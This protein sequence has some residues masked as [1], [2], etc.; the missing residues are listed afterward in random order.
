M[1]L[2]VAKANLM[3]AMKTLRLRWDRA[4]EHWDDQASRQF[5]QEFIA[6]L[7]AK[8]LAAAK[9]L[10]QVAELTAQVRRDCGDDAPD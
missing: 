3:D 6:H 9:G 8:V 1:S 5:E 2:S 10:D 4:K 7:D